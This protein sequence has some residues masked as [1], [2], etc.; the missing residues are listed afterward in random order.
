MS[1][2]LK[3]ICE[4]HI[5]N[6]EIKFVIKILQFFIS[7]NTYIDVLTLLKMTIQIKLCL[8]DIEN[9]RFIYIII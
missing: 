3:L 1:I 5:F 7:Y 9:Y 4:I 6:K 8:Q 2:C